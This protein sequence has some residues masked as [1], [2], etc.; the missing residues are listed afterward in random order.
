VEQDTDPVSD[1]KEKLVVS[2]CRLIYLFMLKDA[3]LLR[4]DCSQPSGRM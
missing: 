4:W 2:P 1:K 3:G